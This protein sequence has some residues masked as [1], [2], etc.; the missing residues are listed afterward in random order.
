MRLGWAGR[1]VISGVSLTL[2]LRTMANPIPRSLSGWRV[3][4]FISTTSPGSY[5]RPSTPTWRRNTDWKEATAGTRG[6]MP[7]SCAIMRRWSMRRATSSP[8]GQ[9]VEQVW[10]DAHS[11]MVV[12]LRTS[13]SRPSCTARSTWFGP[14]QR[15]RTAGSRRALDALGAEVGVLF[16]SLEQILR[17]PALVHYRGPALVHYRGPALVQPA[18]AGYSS[19]EG[20]LPQTAGWSAGW[21]I[22]VS[23]S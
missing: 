18:A 3:R 15:T 21:V 22:L 13:S 12:E 14:D 5:E 4:R 1:R 17:Q 2:R 8:C 16:C 20:L 19:T 6:A 23:K 7:R 9:R 11:Q 10:Q